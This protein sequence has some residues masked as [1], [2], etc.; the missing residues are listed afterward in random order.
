MSWADT[1]NAMFDALVAQY[2]ADDSRGGRPFPTVNGLIP[3][4]LLLL[5]TPSIVSA[6]ARINAT[7][8]AIP[9]VALTS[10]DDSE[11]LNSGVAATDVTGSDAAVALPALGVG[12]VVADGTNGITAA[13]YVA[14]L[15][16]SGASWQRYNT[17]PLQLF[18]F[19]VSADGTNAGFVVPVRQL[20]NDWDIVI[21][22]ATALLDTYGATGNCD[23]TEAA[24]YF[25]ALFTLGSDLDALSEAPLDTNSISGAL[26][27]AFNAS[28]SAVQALAQKGGAAVADIANLA[29]QVAGAGIGGF[30]SSAG[31]LTLA[32][33]A[34]AV[35]LVVK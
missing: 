21:N 4:Q 29:G 8:N 14:G 9:A 2:G 5:F 13:Q 19:A 27:A 22:Q 15:G 10:Q 26:N 23:P 24:A 17:S 30:L 20:L 33:A 25:N 28:A 6:V 7:G 35:F 12:V 1:C 34:V 3:A 11:Q 32:V 18:E 31:G 16:L